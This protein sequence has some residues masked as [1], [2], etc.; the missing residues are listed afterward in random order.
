MLM[1]MPATSAAT[2]FAAFNAIAALRVPIWQITWVL[3]RAH[4]RNTMGPVG[5]RANSTHATPLE[6]YDTTLEQAPS[7]SSIVSWL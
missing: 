2:T 1:S 3:S 4:V 5:E 7:F 6:L